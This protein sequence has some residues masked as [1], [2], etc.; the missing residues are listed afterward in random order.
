MIIYHTTFHV[1]GDIWAEGLNYP[2]QR[3]IPEATG[4][5]LLSKPVM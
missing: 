1:D 5:G 3:Y 2:K 4:S